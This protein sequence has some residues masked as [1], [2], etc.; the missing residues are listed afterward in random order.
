MFTVSG[1]WH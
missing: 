1:R